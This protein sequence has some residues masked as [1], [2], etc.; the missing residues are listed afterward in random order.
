LRRGIDTASQM[1]KSATPQIRSC[2]RMRKT[3]LLPASDIR[4]VRSSSR[5]VCYAAIA[6][7]HYGERVMIIYLILSIVI[8]AST[9]WPTQFGR[10]LSP[11]VPLL[12]MTFVLVDQI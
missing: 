8:I 1:S 11:L 9:P 2:L 5:S 4:T 6:L 12:A 10:Y 3:S 7:W